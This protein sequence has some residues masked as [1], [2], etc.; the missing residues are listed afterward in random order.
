MQMSF[1]LLP[2]TWKRILSIT[3]KGKFMYSQSFEKLAAHYN[4]RSDFY[5]A[6]W[7]KFKREVSP[8]E[9]GTYKHIEVD[10]ADRPDR[11]ETRTSLVFRIYSFMGAG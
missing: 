8:S 2:N 1:A 4:E 7:L 3:E 9:G 10:P 5:F 11:P 6:A